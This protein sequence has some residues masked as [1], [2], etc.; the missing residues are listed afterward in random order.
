[1]QKLADKN[2]NRVLDL[3]NERLT[4]ERE[5]VKLYDTVI[6]K[7]R[8][9]GRPEANKL[10]EQLQEHRDQEKEHEEWLEEQIRSLRGDTHAKTDMALLAA[11]ESEGISK[12]IT[13]DTAL[14]H[15]L[16]ALLTAEL[17]DNAGWDL[18]VELADE[19]GDSEAKRQF[20]KR[21]HHEEEHLIFLRRAVHRL[22]RREIL[23]ENVGMPTW[24]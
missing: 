15:L 14:S 23:G 13:E 22:A 3:L 4:F 2:R 12:V 8:A 7:V 16:H 9:A 19:A 17:A 21:L 1:M 6:G 5:G 24:P 10:L 11:R 20:R 18:L